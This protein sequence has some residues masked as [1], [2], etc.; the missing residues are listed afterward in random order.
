MITIFPIEERTAL[1]AAKENLD[2]G[3]DAVLEAKDG[4]MPLGRIAFSVSADE[5][6]IT[7]MEDQAP[8]IV[9]GLIKSALSYAGQR[10]IPLVTAR[11][12]PGY[13]KSFLAVGFKE[14]E[15]RFF[16]RLDT[17]TNKCRR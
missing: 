14:K 3:A 17:F 10:E 1:E 11:V 8:F 16:L 4:E 7:A 2:P 5:L 12:L 15:N 13:E 9:D 6:R